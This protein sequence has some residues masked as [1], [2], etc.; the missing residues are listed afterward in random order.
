MLPKGLKRL[1]KSGRLGIREVGCFLTA[2]VLDVIASVQNRDALSH[3]R[4]RR[5]LWTCKLVT[6]IES[7]VSDHNDSTSS[8]GSRPGG[9]AI[10]RLPGC[11]LGLGDVKPRPGMHCP[12]SPSL[13]A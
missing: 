9:S 7:R 2:W 5:C 13:G 3:F 6:S 1:C 8:L 10:L 12:T 4:A 11:E